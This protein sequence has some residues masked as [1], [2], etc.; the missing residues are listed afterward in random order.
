[1]INK[2]ILYALMLSGHWTDFARETKKVILL[3]CQAGKN[4]QPKELIQS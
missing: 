2:N 3:R 4:I 1:M